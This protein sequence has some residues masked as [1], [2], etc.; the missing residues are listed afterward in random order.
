[1]KAISKIILE[2]DKRFEFEAEKTILLLTNEEMVQRSCSV[3]THLSGEKKSL[4]NMMPKEFIG[5]AVQVNIAIHRSC[6]KELSELRQYE[7]EC[8]RN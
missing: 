4:R 2:L 1:M 8:E 7:E 5:I 6:S 3:R